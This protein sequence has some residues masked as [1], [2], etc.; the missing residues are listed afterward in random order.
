MSAGVELTVQQQP[1]PDAGGH[2]HVDHLA[3]ASGHAPPMLT[4]RGQM[5]VVIEIARDTR[6]PGQDAVQGHVAKTRQIGRA[7]HKA[8]DR[9]DR[10]GKPDAQRPHATRRGAILL[11]GFRDGGHD[12]A[13]HVLT[14][15]GS[16]G[17]VPHHGSQAATII[18]NRDP[19]LGAAQ[20]D[21][22][23]GHG[24]RGSEYRRYCQRGRGKGRRV[25]A[26]S[27]APT[28]KAMA[29]ARKMR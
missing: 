13:D 16:L 25:R 1:G 12:P 4:E 23:E 9:I 14:A 2:G 26:A 20:V 7:D 10:S 22:D 28:N 24:C 17:R 18:R 19:Q 29:V 6:R 8:G 11:Q 3:G 27:K 15:A 21:A 5:R